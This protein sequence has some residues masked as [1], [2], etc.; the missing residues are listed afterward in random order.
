MLG[1]ESYL[2]PQRLTLLIETGES[3][4]V[5]PPP[6]PSGSRLSLLC[7]GLVASLQCIWMVPLFLSTATIFRFLVVSSRTRYKFIVASCFTRAIVDSSSLL[8][9]SSRSLA[10]TPSAPIFVVASKDSKIRWRCP[11]I[12]RMLIDPN[13]NRAVA[14][15][16][17]IVSVSFDSIRLDIRFDSASSSE[18]PSLF[19]CCSGGLVLFFLSSSLFCLSSEGAQPE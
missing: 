1:I 5:L 4:E 10:R 14:K 15:I 16:V 17:A 11:F 8:E 19:S 7:F 3:S 13:W 2:T 12:I 9:L 18:S 6:W